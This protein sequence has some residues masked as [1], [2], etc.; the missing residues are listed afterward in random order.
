LLTTPVWRYVRL[1]PC[2]D[3][4]ANI[5]LAVSGG[6]P[7]IVEERRGRGRCIVVATA[8]T[9]DAVDEVNGTRLPWTAWPIW[10]SFPPLILEMARQAAELRDESRNRQVG[11]E[12]TGHLP[13]G[14]SWQAPVITSPTGERVP[15]VQLDV[16]AGTWSLSPAASAGIFQV[17]HDFPAAPAQLYAVNLDP[18]ESRVSRLEWPR[19]PPNLEV[20]AAS[21]GA[22]A[23]SAPAQRFDRRWSRGLLGGLLVVLLSETVLASR[24]GG[25]LRAPRPVAGGRR[26]VA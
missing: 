5:A 10:P 6:D 25:G 1:E 26:D 7:I 24:L 19:L 13:A 23:E 8:V 16:T 17:R 11:D 3:G 21:A 22:P 15:H 2:A 20:R 9:D 14:G 18:V 12:L 4:T